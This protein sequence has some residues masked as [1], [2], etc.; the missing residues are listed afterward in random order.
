MLMKTVADFR[1]PVHVH[2]VDG[3]QAGFADGEFAADDF[4]DGALE[5]F[6]DSL[7]S[8]GGHA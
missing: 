2:V 6:A 1:S 8:E 7:V 4:A 3:D 5:Q